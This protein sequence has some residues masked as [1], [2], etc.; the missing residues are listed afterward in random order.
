MYRLF[1]IEEV[2]DIDPEIKI[3]LNFHD[4]KQIYFQ[5]QELIDTDDF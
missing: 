3:G 2:T 5:Y 1:L 4:N